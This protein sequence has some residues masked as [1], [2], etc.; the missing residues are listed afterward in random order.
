MDEGD[1]EIGS[2]DVGDSQIQVL[3]SLPLSLKSSKQER[4]K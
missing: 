1:Q 4:Q 3:K 2:E